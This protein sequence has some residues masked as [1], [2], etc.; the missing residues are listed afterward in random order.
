MNIIPYCIFLV[1]VTIAACS[2][3]LLKKSAQ[4]TYRK[5]IFEYLNIY[6]IVGYLMLLA[7]MLLQIKAFKNLI[8]KNGAI[9]EALGYIIVM[10][11]SY[12]FFQEK[13]TRNKLIGTLFILI[14]ITVFYL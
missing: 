2:Q 10:V 9:M 13:I 7:S 1:G 3:I 4:K 12:F 5:P 8:Y 11:L 14:G 6:V